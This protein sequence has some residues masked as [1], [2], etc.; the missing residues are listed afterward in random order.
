MITMTSAPPITVSSDIDAITD[1]VLRR[2]FIDLPKDQADA[3]VRMVLEC[4]QEAANPA[5][6]RIEGQL[7]NVFANLRYKDR[8][9]MKLSTRDGDAVAL[10]GLLST[11]EGDALAD[12]LR[13]LVGHNVVLWVEDQPEASR[14]YPVVL[15]AT[16]TGKG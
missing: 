12:Y 5:V 1:L 2:Q 16:S 13:S 7:L 8:Q 15:Q 9:Y 6:R 11:P 3:I 10:T 14:T 4:A